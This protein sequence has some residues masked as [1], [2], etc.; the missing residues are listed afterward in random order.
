MYLSLYLK[1]HKK[2]YYNLLQKVRE[3]SEWELWI[4]FF[5]LGVKETANL[6]SNKAQ[7]ILKKFEENKKLLGSRFFKDPLN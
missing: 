6:A 5:L 2:E 1:S 7:F 4:N 3:T